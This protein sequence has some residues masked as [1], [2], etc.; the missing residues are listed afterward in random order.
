MFFDYILQ[1]VLVLQPFSVRTLSSLGPGAELLP[2]AT[3]ID[4]KIEVEQRIPQNQEKSSPGAP[5]G[6]KCE[7]GSTAGVTLLGSGGPYIETKR[8]NGTNKH[9][10]DHTRQWV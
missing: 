8:A 2:Q 7:F 5:K 10:D 1:F 6:R 9:T 3:E 4:P